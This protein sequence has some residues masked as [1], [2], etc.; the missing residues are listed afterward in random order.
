MEINTTIN[1]ILIH[2]VISKFLLLY[3][4]TKY[5][6]DIEMSELV[7][8]SLIILFISLLIFGPKKNKPMEIG[9]ILAVFFG[10]IYFFADKTMP[11]YIYLSSIGICMFIYGWIRY[12]RENSKGKTND[13]K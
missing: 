12:K 7:R 2:R 3:I 5:K 11:S 8:Y 6:G 1:Y 9:I 4:I 10:G 13:R